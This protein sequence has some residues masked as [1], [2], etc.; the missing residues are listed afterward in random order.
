MNAVLSFLSRDWAG[1][2]IAA[3]VAAPALLLKGPVSWLFLA[4]G[5]AA[6]LGALAQILQT[7]WIAR[8]FPA[9]GLHVATSMGKLHVL[10]EGERARLPSIVFFAGAH[11]PGGAIYHL[12]CALRTVTRSILIDR[13]GTGWSDPARFPVTTARE[14]DAI[15]EALKAAGE[16]GPFVLCGH[17][18]GG[19]LAANIAKR[20]PAETAALALLDPT[21]P[22]IIIY[23]P[24]LG[25]EKMSGM[26]LRRGFAALFG[27]HLDPNGNAARRN[28]AAK[29]LID[30]SE[31]LMGPMLAPVRALGKRARSAFADA[32]IY[33]ELT[34]AGM[35]AA[36]WEI[37]VYEHELDGMPVYLIAPGDAPEVDAMADALFNHGAQAR[38]MKIILNRGRERFMS[39]S[40]RAQRI[41]APAGSGHNFP[42]EEANWT[43]AQLK[44]IVESAAPSARVR[45]ARVNTA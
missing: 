15:L 21:P 40:D 16:N 28:P 30:E 3:I 25:A 10:A 9:P 19:L 22:D 20:A 18:F 39:V 36:G 29:K 42:F 24:P 4:A 11:A 17:S 31:A 34:P 43:I 12:H 37:G 23:G 33:R 13:P 8:R 38:R 44:S 1:L 32:S 14:S 2:V 45:D 41:V 26:S 27:I 6:L 35:G 5:G 7:R